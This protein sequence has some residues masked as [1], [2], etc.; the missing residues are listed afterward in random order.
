MPAESTEFGKALWLRDAI[1]G[2]CEAHRVGG[3]TQIS[4]FWM[5][6]LQV[7]EVDFDDSRRARTIVLADAPG[8]A[9]DV[10]LQVQDLPWHQLD[11]DILV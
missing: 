10:L 1:G 8:I 9:V 7:V 3:C 5:S 2:I 4:I 11:D 6:S